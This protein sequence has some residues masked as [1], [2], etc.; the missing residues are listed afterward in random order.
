MFLG[1]ALVRRRIGAEINLSRMVFFIEISKNLPEA[2]LCALRQVATL[3]TLMSS[4]ALLPHSLI[5]EE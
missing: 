5:R 2:C 1:V 3:R 4:N